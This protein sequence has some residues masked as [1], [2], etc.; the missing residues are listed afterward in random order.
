M[1]DVF[2]WTDKEALSQIRELAQA[3]KQRKDAEHKALGIGPSDHDLERILGILNALDEQVDDLQTCSELAESWV[4]GNKTHVLE[5]LEQGGAVYVAVLFEQGVTD[6][7]LTP[8]DT[9]RIANGLS[10][11]RLDRNERSL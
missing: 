6:G 7:V 9:R 2:T 3:M 11:R 5:Q 4:N 10:M 8:D 1:S